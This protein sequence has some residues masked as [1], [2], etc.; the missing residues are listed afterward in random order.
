MLI[1]NT[2]AHGELEVPSLRSVVPDGKW[3]PGETYDIDD[4]IAEGLLCE[5][6]TFVAARA[7]KAKAEEKS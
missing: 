5:P 6:A 4:D 7:P 3:A 2:G 1:T